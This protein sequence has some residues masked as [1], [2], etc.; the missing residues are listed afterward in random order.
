MSDSVDDVV[1]A[2]TG[3]AIGRELIGRIRAALERQ[4][5][6][7]DEAAH[8]AVSIAPQYLDVLAAPEILD[9]LFTKIIG[10]DS[11]LVPPTERT[12]P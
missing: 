4:G 10:R 11:P 12:G 5:M 3:L 7:V 6:A 9:K 1:D 8:M 2:I